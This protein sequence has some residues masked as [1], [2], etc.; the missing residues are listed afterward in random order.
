MFLSLE[1]MPSSI[2]LSMK[3]AVSGLMI[4]SLAIAARCGLCTTERA[5]ISLS[6]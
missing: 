4:F 5:L 3:P 6:R 1:R 2:M